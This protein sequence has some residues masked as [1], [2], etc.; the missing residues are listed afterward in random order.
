[1]NRCLLLGFI[2]FASS[3]LTVPS[4]A[5]AQVDGASYQSP[6]FGYRLSWDA[7]WWVDDEDVIEGSDYLVLTNG[8]V[9]LEVTGTDVFGG[10]TRPCVSNA[11]SFV[12]SLSDTGDV[13][14]LR[15]ANLKPVEFYQDDRAVLGLSFPLALEDGSITDFGAYIECRTVV[16]GISVVQFAATGPLDALLSTKP[17]V[18]ALIDGIMMP[19][20]GEKGPVVAAGPWRVSVVAVQRDEAIPALGLTEKE[21]KRWLVIAS[22]VTNWGDQDTV[23]PTGDLL[24][25]QVDGSKP[26]RLAPA[27]T[28]KAARALGIAPADP[29]AGVSIGVDQTTRI[30]LVFQVSAST[31]ESAL[32]V[33]DQRLPLA[34]A[35]GLDGDL[36]ELPGIVSPPFLTEV[37]VEYVPDGSHI[38]VSDSIGAPR[39][40]SLLGNVTPDNDECYADEATNRL[41]DLAGDTVWIEIEPTADET[42]GVYLWRIRGDGSYRMIN[43][44][45]V[46]GGFGAATDEQGRFTAWLQSTQLAA[47]GSTAGLWSACSGA[48]D[49]NLPGSDVIARRTGSASEATGS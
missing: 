10:R 4:P 49:S 44:E 33:D 17:A 40:L 18:E 25:S 37:T 20:T 19:S 27:S 21:G 35:A 23:F 24:V 34:M 41:T 3:A 15:G 38:V 47:E 2:L 30:V 46:A 31:R 28:A 42:D 14:N 48:P 12:I 5:T 11:R 16:P 13:E 22:D 45:L 7:S 39:R 9:Y 36:T 32:V 29:K 1:M 8:L 43:Q 26:T 6:T